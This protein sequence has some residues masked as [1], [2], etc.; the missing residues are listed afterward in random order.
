MRPLDPTMLAWE[1]YL[2]VSVFNLLDCKFHFYPPLAPV[3][4]TSSDSIK[5]RGLSSNILAC[6]DIKCLYTLHLVVD[7]VC[8]ISID[9]CI[10]GVA[11][12]PMGGFFGTFSSLSATKLGSIAIE[13]NY[14]YGNLCQ[15]L[16]HCIWIICVYIFFVH[17][18]LL[19][20]NIGKGY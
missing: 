1:L 17:L 2:N 18:Q 5:P 9:V 4:V 7:Y 10:V 3:A 14:V 12:T 16:L 15:C 8:L 20:K 6:T 11:H 13:G 19:L